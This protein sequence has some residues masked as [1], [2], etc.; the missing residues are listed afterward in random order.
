MQQVIEAIVRKFSEHSVV[1]DEVVD[2]LNRLPGQIR[3]FPARHDIVR[4]G[5][6]PTVS[7]VVISG[8]LARYHTLRSGRRQYLSFHTSGDFPDVQAL[9]IE[10]MDHSLC[11]INDATVALIPHDDLEAAFKRCP[12]LAIALWRETLIDAAIFREAITNNSARKPQARVAHFFCECYYRARAG[13]HE[14]PGFC[15]LPINQ[16]QL[17]ETLGISIVTANR[18]VQALRR[19]KAVDWKDGLLHVIDWLKLADIGEFDP[20]YLHLRRTPRL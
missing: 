1:S 3:L 2:E 6:K 7:V 5:D 17:G 12:A 4:Q 10:K 16:A 18:A 11:A 14:R 20:T 9:Y 15:T 13:R 19:T 8:L